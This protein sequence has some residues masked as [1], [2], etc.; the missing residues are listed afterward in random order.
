MTNEA[1][2]SKIMKNNLRC[3]K[4]EYALRDF[5]EKAAGVSFYELLRKVG[6][7]RPG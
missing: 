2:S 7:E 5:R 3:E 4:Q 1:V 6:L